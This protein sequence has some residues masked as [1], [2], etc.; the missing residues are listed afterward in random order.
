MPYSFAFFRTNSAGASVRLLTLSVTVPFVATFTLNPN[1][2]EFVLTQSQVKVPEDTITCIHMEGSGCYGQ[3]GADDVSL[4]AALIA[5]AVPGR[6]VRLQWMR[7]DEFAAE[8]FGAPMAVQSPLFV[9]SAA[10]AEQSR[11]RVPR[12]GDDDAVA[13]DARR[14]GRAAGPERQAAEA[15]RPALGYLKS[16]SAGR[17]SLDKTRKNAKGEYHDQRDS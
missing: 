6:P 16:T 9:S 2:G 3:N 5:R 4:D 8:P 15:A 7:E 12:A 11:K 1:L 14:G 13:P 10:A 17:G